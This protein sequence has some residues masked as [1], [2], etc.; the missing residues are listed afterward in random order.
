MYLAAFY[1]DT[2]ILRLREVKGSTQDHTATQVCLTPKHALFPFCFSGC[3]TVANLLC[4][5]D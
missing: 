4:D 1:I 3:F 5:L 2:Q